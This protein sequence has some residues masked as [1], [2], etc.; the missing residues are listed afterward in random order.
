MH[1]WYSIM[2]VSLLFDDY[3]NNA[4]IMLMAQTGK[5]AV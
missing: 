1:Y 3:L 4:Y 2:T 5:M